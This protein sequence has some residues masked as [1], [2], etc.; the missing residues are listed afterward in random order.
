MIWGGLGRLTAVGSCKGERV[1]NGAN[2]SKLIGVTSEEPR[3]LAMS[4][5][6][7]APSADPT[8]FCREDD[9]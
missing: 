4:V 5:L 9:S 6:Y 3:S 2:R 1:E 7:Q 8:Q